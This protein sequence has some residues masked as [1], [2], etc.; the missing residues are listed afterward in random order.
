MTTIQQ[1]TYDQTFGLEV[2]CLEILA[3]VFGDGWE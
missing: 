2:L 3:F 1:G